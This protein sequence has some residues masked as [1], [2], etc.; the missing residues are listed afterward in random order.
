VISIFLL[1]RDKVEKAL[2]DKGCTQI[3]S[4]LPEHSAWTT[5][6]GNSFLV[7][8]VGPD[9]MTPAWTLEE[10]IEDIDKNKPTNH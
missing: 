2:A 6:C 9:L 4:P 10:I 3:E 7:P 5:A 8:Q 1:S